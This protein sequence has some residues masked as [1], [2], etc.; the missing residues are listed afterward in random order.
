MVETVKS[1]AEVTIAYMRL[2]EDE[3]ILLSRGREEGS[4]DE[5]MRIVKN[6][7]ERGMDEKDIYALAE[8]DKSFIDRVKLQSRLKS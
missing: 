4:E 5:K 3:R 1:D 7:L 6:M 8:C 2:M